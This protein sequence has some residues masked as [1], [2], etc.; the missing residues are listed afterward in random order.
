MTAAKATERAKTATAAVRATADSRGD[1]KGNGRGDGA[2]GG[3]SDGN[4]IIDGKT[5]YR[6]VYDIYYDMAM[7]IVRNGGELP[8]DLKAFIEKYYG[9][10]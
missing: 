7:E 8:A 4:Q 1:G 9:S 10:I 6:D 5:D 3:W 2:G